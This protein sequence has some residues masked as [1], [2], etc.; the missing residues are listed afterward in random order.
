MAVTC[1]RFAR[2]LT[3][4]FEA[5][6]TIEASLL[7]VGGN[8]AHTD[9]SAN[10]AGLDAVTTNG[11]PLTK[12]GPFP[13]PKPGFSGTDER[14]SHVRHVSFAC[15]FRCKVVQWFSVSCASRKP[16]VNENPLETI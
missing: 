10:K 4:G 8:G 2:F 1:A 13:L 16:G 6:A 7:C 11:I 15:I 5:D 9:S 12:S 14:D 3:G